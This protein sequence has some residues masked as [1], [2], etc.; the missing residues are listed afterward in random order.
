M[1]IQF[2]K[3]YCHLF[4]KILRKFKRTLHFS[5]IKFDKLLFKNTES[6][7]DSKNLDSLEAINDLNFDFIRY[8]YRS[9]KTLMSYKTQCFIYLFSKDF[10][11]NIKVL[12]DYN[13]KDNLRFKNISKFIY[14]CNGQ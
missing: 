12:K 3:S 7:N 2:L 5:E 9:K 10:Y 1:I 11:K 13:F 4:I 6:I 14:L 8:I